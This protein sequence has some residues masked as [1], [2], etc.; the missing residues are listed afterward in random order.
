MAPPP[1]VVAHRAGND[2]ALLA[3]AEAVPVRLVEADVHLFAGRLEI[4]HLKTAGPVPILWDRW[5]L[6]PSWVPRLL[7][8]ELLEAVAP[9]TELM[10]DLKGRDPRLPGRVAASIGN[11]RVTL[12]SQNWRLLEPLA[13]V[14]GAR[15]VHSVGSRRRLAA[16][17][18]RFGGR[19][20]AGVSIHRDLLDAN[21]VAGLKRV[22][23]VVM[24]W[25][26]A[27]VEQA[28]QLAAM[29]VDG[30]ITE[31]FEALAAA[32]NSAPSMAAA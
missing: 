12:C 25:P 20:L 30:V 19:R 13:R 29:G 18:R 21:T 17:H 32:L 27:T 24:T 22:A 1:F 8:G 10:L 28:R 5:K 15:L 26:V 6:A 14:P 9:G 11:R 31:N 7:L 16:L 23:A 2:L 3:R 4:R